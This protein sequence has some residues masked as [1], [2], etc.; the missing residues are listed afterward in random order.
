MSLTI[1]SQFHYNNINT[2]IYYV[3][4]YMHVQYEYNSKLLTVGP[5]YNSGSCD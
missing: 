5:Y 2:A 3:L 4:L 1:I